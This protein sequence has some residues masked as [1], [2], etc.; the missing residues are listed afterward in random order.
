MPEWLI[1]CGLVCDVL[2]G[3]YPVAFSIMGLCIVILIFLRLR[4]IDKHVTKM[5]NE[6]EELKQLARF[7]YC[8][9]C[10]YKDTCNRRIAEM[11]ECTYEY[12][13]SL[14]TR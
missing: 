3:K 10:G 1:N 5:Q 11:D 8:E 2:T 7:P 12:R 9:E 14:V 4:R 13:K 6:A